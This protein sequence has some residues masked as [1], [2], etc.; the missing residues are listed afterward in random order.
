MLK[1]LYIKNFILLKEAKIDFTK[2]FNVIAGET[3]AGKSII[4][5]AI[6]CV[7]GAKTNK[8]MILGD[9]NAVIEAVFKQES[10]KGGKEITVSRQI[11]SCSKFRLDG[12]LTTSD[13]ILELRKNLLDIHSQHQTYT[14]MQSKNHIVLLDNYIS[15]KHPEFFELLK[16]YKETYFEYKNLQK[17]L[18]NLKEN[19]QNNLKE[20]DFLKFE[21]NEIDEASVK[22]N[23]EE[24]LIEEL[25]I[26]SSAQTLKEETYK[27]HWALSGSNES[28]VEALSKIKYTI[29]NCAQTDKGLSDT[30][31][32]IYDC[33]ENLKD[34]SNS[35]RDYSSSLECNPNRIDELNERIS[36]IQKLKRKYG[37]NLDEERNKLQEQLNDLT[38]GD[39]NLDELE[40]NFEILSSSIDF[41]LEKITD[42]RKKE[43]KI[44]E[45]LVIKEL[46]GLELKDAKFEINIEE[47]EKNELGKDKVEFLISA[48]KSSI[49]PLP[50]SKVASG[51]EI[52][53]VMLSLK[54]VFASTDN[55]STIIF[56]EID[57]GISG[58]TS[59]AVRDCM[60]KVSK[61][62][63]IICITHQPIIAAKADNFIWI[64]KEND[65]STNIKINILNDD[66]RLDKL[67]QIAGGS[68]N[69][70]SLD[71]AKT[72]I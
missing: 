27:A 55:I 48:N 30:L 44:L 54:T 13:E 45:E 66:T 62:T 37:K 65:I 11:G 14:Y 23:E 19:Y 64:E 61:D 2:G 49:K 50:L 71:F 40:K 12:I 57:T 28:I 25:N 18:E 70:Q 16:N 20:I 5:K 33:Y 60:L 8:D 43:A 1:S 4:I 53:R 17:K 59:T 6:D 41:M 7:L 38:S 39:N 36:L 52:S 67:A 15:K 21:L 29:E 47:V 26:Q 68:V 10:E 35:L 22:E 3:G 69:Q 51:G 34:A 63:Q 72:L 31:N 56:D 32:V 42:F 9:D 24:E 46:E 58:V